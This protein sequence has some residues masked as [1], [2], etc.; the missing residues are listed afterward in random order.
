MVRWAPYA[1]LRISAFFCAGILLYNLT[2]K[3][4][5]WLPGVFAFF[6]ATYAVA[7][8]LSRQIKNTFFTN[9]TGC[10]GLASFLVLGMLLTQQHTEKWQPNHLLHQKGTVT[11]YIAV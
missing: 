8:L 5:G 4:F 3:Y 2:G 1:F 10:L 7:V 6:V 9:L 11:A